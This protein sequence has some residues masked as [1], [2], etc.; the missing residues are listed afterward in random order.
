MYIGGPLTNDDFE[1]LDQ[2]KSYELF[3]IAFILVRFEILSYNELMLPNLTAS[4]FEFSATSLAIMPKGNVKKPKR[5]S[6]KSLPDSAYKTL[7]LSLSTKTL[8]HVLSPC[9]RIDF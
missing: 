2:F 6:T 4:I 5:T 8:R 3:F 9:S 1:M 7:C